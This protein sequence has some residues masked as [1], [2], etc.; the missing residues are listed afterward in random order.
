M[1]EILL[2]N[3]EVALVLLNPQDNSLNNSHQIF[4][5]EETQNNQIELIESNLKFLSALSMFDN[6]EY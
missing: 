5:S 6:F 2:E 4:S 1:S 3:K